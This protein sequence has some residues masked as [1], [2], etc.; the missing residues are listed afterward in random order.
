[1]T[2]VKAID[3]ILKVISLVDLLHTNNI[4]HTNLCPEEI[5]L[6][7]GSVESMCFANLYH[8]NWNVKQV[9]NIELP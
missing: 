9:M 7:G 6:K 1:M 8:A 5:F 4:I 3:L 2:E